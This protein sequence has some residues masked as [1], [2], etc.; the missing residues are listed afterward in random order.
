LEVKSKTNI[1]V[2]EE[3]IRARTAGFKNE[4]SRKEW[5][6]LRSPEYFRQILR[7]AG[8]SH[9]K[10]IFDQPGIWVEMQKEAI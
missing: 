7:Q 8:I 1:V 4:Q 6:R 5:E 3:F 2:R 9:F 10:L